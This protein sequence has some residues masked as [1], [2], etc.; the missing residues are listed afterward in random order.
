M[1]Y[2][3]REVVFDRQTAPRL[4]VA[5][6]RVRS[7]LFWQRRAAGEFAEG[8]VTY[9]LEVG[10]ADFAGVEAVAGE[11]AQKGKEGHSLAEGGIF[12]GIFAV[13]DQV[14]DFFLLLWGAFHEEVAVA[15]GT[16][17]IEPVKAAA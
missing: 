17:G 6:L 1:R 8:G 5:S 12:F 14:E 4:A 3:L 11:I 15:V 16:S 13:G 7:G 2:A 9:I 10:D